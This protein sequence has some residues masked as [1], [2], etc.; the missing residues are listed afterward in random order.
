M[1]ATRAEMWTKV[2]RI[3]FQTQQD[4]GHWDKDSK[5]PSHI[6]PRMALA[7]ADIEK[8]RIPLS[9]EFRR[10]ISERRERTENWIK[11]HVPQRPEKTE[12][13]V[14][15]VTYELQR[16]DPARAK[17]LLDELLSRRCEDGGW[18]IKKGDPSHLLVTSVV[19]LGLKTGGL[20]NDDP[21]V[22]D[23]QRYLLGK[24][25][26][27]GRWRELGRH[28]HPEAYHPAYDAWTTGYAVAALSQ[29]MPKLSPGAKR[30]FA[31]AQELVAEVEQLTRSAADGY[32]GQADRSGDPTQSETPLEPSKVSS[33]QT[34]TKELDE[35]RP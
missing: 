4:D 15:W 22:A 6:A 14:G 21:V 3:A 2:L 16:G 17:Q 32:T 20:P 28:F 29:T 33:A 18:G 13:L 23:T 27:D 7:L 11:S 24:Q 10:E 35:S 31:P 9:A 5:E 26:E 30:I 12:N 1:S 19:L 8:S 25:S 34:L